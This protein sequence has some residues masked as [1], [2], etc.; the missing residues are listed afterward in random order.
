MHAPASAR[1]TVDH[2]T[3]SDST[4]LPPPVAAEADI[5]DAAEATEAVGSNPSRRDPRP[6]EARDAAADV[7]WAMLCCDARTARTVAATVRSPMKAPCAATDDVPAARVRCAVAARAF[8]FPASVACVALA[9]RVIAPPWLPKSR[10][11]RVCGSLLARVPT[12]AWA[13]EDAR[14]SVGA[15]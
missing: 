3:C 11:C 12:S 10:V 2:S 6:T 13:S 8:A 1:D 5:A 7:R 14:K 9:A 4:R 15:G